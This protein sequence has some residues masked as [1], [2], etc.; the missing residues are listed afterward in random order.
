MNPLNDLQIC[1]VTTTQYQF[2][3]ADIYARYIY[4]SFGIASKVL[5]R[6]FKCFD[7]ARFETDEKYE[8][9]PYTINNRN[10]LGQCI[11]AIQCGYCFRLSNWSRLLDKSKN[12]ILFVF[13]DMSKLTSRLIDEVKN[14]N[15]DNRIVLI[16]EGNN[17]YSDSL[18]SKNE[19]LWHLQHLISRI[20]FGIGRSSKVI[21]DNPKIDTA[22]V[23]D[24]DRYKSLEK[25]KNQNV[26][27]QNQDILLCAVDFFQH[28][29]QASTH[30]LNCDILFL[31]QPFYKNGRFF[32]EEN[33]CLSA[34]FRYLP[35]T[36]RILIKPHPRDCAGKY[37]RLADSFCN[38][39]VI[40][41]ELSAFPVEALLAVTEIMTVL[42]I[43]SSAA[44]TLANLSS[45]IDAV[46]LR[47]LPEAIALRE[48]LLE[49]GEE[50]PNIKEEQFVGKNNNIFRPKSSAEYQK[51]IEETLRRARGHTALFKTNHT[52][53]FEEINTII[54]SGNSIK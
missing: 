17:T 24:P 32:E 41:D 53:S 48:R 19:M 45:N 54:E 30:H 52:V 49:I 12:T 33:Q 13:N 4:D 31:G 10:L 43:E 39:F 3:I 42:T 8:I 6:R 44:I 1:F 38:V 23:K 29:T 11:F 51:V 50:L 22:I 46:I 16:E 37:N 15:N 2:M 28:Y 21:G 36:T 34:L 47:E 20:L 27:Q 9:I 5:I 14:H 40:D 25:S 7:I 18:E 35:S 26:V